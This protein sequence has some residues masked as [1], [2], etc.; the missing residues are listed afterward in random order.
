MTRR[1]GIAALVFIAVVWGC[2]FP[3]IK[4]TLSQASPL[5]FLAIRFLLASVFVLPWLRGVTRHELLGGLVLAV[6]FWAGFVFQTVG[7]AHTTPSRS[8]F[9]T[10]L[11]TP[12]VPVAYFLVYRRT[13]SVTTALAVLV[14]GVGMYL[15]TRPSGSGG[16]INV[17]DVLTLGCAVMFA[18]QIVAAGHFTPTARP[19]RLLALQLTATGLLSALAAPLFETPR[20]V[21][22]SG[23]ALAIAFLSVIATVTF[24][25]QLGAQRVVS[26]A[27][28][29]IIFTLEALAAAVTSWI[30]LGETLTLVQWAGGLLILV[31][32]VLPFVG[33]A[34][35]PAPASYG[36]PKIESGPWRPTHP[37]ASRWER[38][39]LRGS[40]GG[41]PGG[42]GQGPE[43]RH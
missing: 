11:S 29:A 26:P 30:V 36:S 13:P 20:L 33:A 7:L 4:Q 15:L 39:E 21:L 23:V 43:E 32:A 22:T 24:Y 42:V 31:G 37:S 34:G 17:G 19:E 14:T 41:D 18:F 5:L 28:T 25:L 12:L 10:G 27:L 6:L 16:G 8:A 1:Q 9:I 2:C 35:W 3:L 38:A 40:A